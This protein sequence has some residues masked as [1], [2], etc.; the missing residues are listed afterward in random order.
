M[1]IHRNYDETDDFYFHLLFNIGKTYRDSLVAIHSNESLHA[2]FKEHELPR[3]SV[4]WVI[5]VEFKRQRHM[6]CFSNSSDHAV[7]GTWVIVP[8]GP[9]EHN[10]FDCGLV[11]ASARW[12][13]ASRHFSDFSLCPPST[14]PVIVDR[15]QLFHRAAVSKGLSPVLR[16]LEGE[17]AK[18]FHTYHPSR[19]RVALRVARIT[20]HRL[21]LGI[22][23]VD[24]ELQFDGKRLCLYYTSKNP[25][26]FDMLNKELY[27]L[28]HTRIWLENI[29]HSFQVPSTDKNLGIR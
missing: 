26:R 20:V 6:R 11:V 4:V 7:P 28:F 25:V 27:R 18:I 12:H 29:S 8:V 22:H 24:C 9:P 23:L 15:A 19:E 16:V 1:D 14:T 2:I 21:S 3:D 10:G 13:P 17:E 5:L